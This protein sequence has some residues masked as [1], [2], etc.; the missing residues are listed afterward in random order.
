VCRWNREFPAGWATSVSWRPDM[1]SVIFLSTSD[2]KNLFAIHRAFETTKWAAELKTQ[3][4]ARCAFSQSM[5]YVG[6]LIGKFFA[7]DINTGEIKW[8]FATEGYNKFHLNYFKPD[9]DYRDDILEVV[10][11]DAGFQLAQY[12]C[13]A[14]YSTAA[15]TN[16]EIIFSSGEGL[17]YCLSR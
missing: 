5:C 16:D 7:I 1:D 9:D 11:D 14:I 3:C 13:G 4:F 17:V 12:K 2:P 15:I 6:T 8:T 10:K